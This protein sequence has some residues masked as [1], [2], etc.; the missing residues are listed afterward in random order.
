MNKR[1]PL[2][3]EHVKL[4]AKMVPFAG[5]DMPVQY[6]AVI[7]EHTAVRERA[8]LFDTSHMGEADVRGSDAAAFLQSLIS[9]D[10]NRLAPGRCFYTALTNDRGGCVDDLYVYKRADNDYFLVLNASRAAEDLAW[11]RAHLRDFKVELT[12]ISEATAMLALQGPNTAAIMKALGAPALPPRFGFAE[13][14]F[15]GIQGTVSR[16]GYTGEDGVEI[17]LAA[18][19][20]PALWRA[21]ID[22]G[23]A[24]A[25][26]GARD[27]L[28]L[29]SA[30][31]LYGHELTEDITPI[32][33]GIG[34]VVARGKMF[35]GSDVVYRQLNQGADKCIAAFELLERGVPREGYE[36]H[37]GGRQV[38]RV[39]SGAFS[40]TL[41]KGIGLALVEAP[42]K[43][44]GTEITILIRDRHYA[45]RVVAR[46]FILFA[47][48][49]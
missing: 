9:N 32:E 7:D 27:T 15:F 38:G 10:I 1:T 16:T 36:V 2:Y 21:I 42:F 6:T 12:D 19:G 43:K 5:W 25:G 26:L 4:G 28:R 47:G 24:P 34:F 45:G 30:Y 20:A 17:Y 13:M 8:G 11:L 46:P 49:K 39:T 31:S 29:E 14:K 33:A 18:S 23:A 44:I 48:G 37:S 40:P 35:P 41:K 3:D 22:A